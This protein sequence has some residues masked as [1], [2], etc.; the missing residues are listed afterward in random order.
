[1]WNFGASAGIPKWRCEANG[2]RSCQ[3]K[4]FSK[5]L[6]ERCIGHFVAA[7]FK[8]FGELR[9]FVNLDEHW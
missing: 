1:M 6:G 7:C 9:V 5:R 4:R 3:R 2:V 8:A